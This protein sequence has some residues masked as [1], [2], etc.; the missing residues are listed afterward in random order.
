MDNILTNKFYYHYKFRLTKNIH[1]T[2]NAVYN[3]LYKNYT[4][5]RRWMY[6]VLL[7]NFMHSLQVITN[8]YVNYKVY[9]LWRHQLLKFTKPPTKSWFQ[10]E[11][12]HFIYTTKMVPIFQNH[13][14]LVEECQWHIGPNK[15]EYQCIRSFDL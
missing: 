11:I 2:V 10:V 4:L 12:N 5:W 3:Y 13:C 6:Y 15:I 1:W 14:P 8:K 9:T 7:K